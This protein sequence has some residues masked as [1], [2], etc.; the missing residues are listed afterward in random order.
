MATSKTRNTP[1][2]SDIVISSY[3]CT[4]KDPEVRKLLPT[5][6]VPEH[7]EFVLSNVSTAIAN[8]LRRTIVSELPVKALNFHDTNFVTTNPFCEI[9]DL[10]K[11]RI[12]QIPIMQNTPQDLKFKLDV[13][14][15]SDSLFDVT[16]DMIKTS[17]GASSDKYFNGTT[18]I[19][20]LE[21]K[22]GL[23]INDIFIDIGVE[24]SDNGAGY[25]VAFNGVR[26]PLDE[27]PFYELY[28]PYDGKLYT[29]KGTGVHSSVS[30]SRK[31]AMSFNTNGTEPPKQII[32]RA[33]QHLSKMLT[34]C[35]DDSLDT[36]VGTNDTYTLSMPNTTDTIGN[37]IARHTC[38]LHPDIK[39]ITYRVD[40]TSHYCDI[41][42]RTD[43]DAK[44]LL[45]GVLTNAIGICNSLADQI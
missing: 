12:R 41:R 8:G 44:K 30:N 7:V 33:L 21:P 42:L 24:N 37:I 10:V 39:L 28:T 25:S 20:T 26:K 14:N 3:G 13:S 9:V 29:N 40:P 4:I 36:L 15:T 19:C 1:H 17:S 11:Q 32:K 5:T 6:C 31:H 45:H 34:S 16:A 2:I 43:A 22:T 38:D 18:L 35:R 23:T 27:E